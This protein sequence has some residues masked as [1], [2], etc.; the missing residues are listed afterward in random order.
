MHGDGIDSIAVSVRI[1]DPFPSSQARSRAD[2]GAFRSNSPTVALL[3]RIVRDVLACCL[4]L[5]STV[6]GIETVDRLL[7]E[8]PTLPNAATDLF[9]QDLETLI[10]KKNSLMLPLLRNRWSHS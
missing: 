1:F 9:R 10:T 4:P 2:V 8:R 7:H 6:F 5:S 3:L